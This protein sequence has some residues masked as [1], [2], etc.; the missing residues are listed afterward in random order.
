MLFRSRSKGLTLQQ[1]AYA[2]AN[3]IYETENKQPLPLDEAAFREVTSAEYM[4]FGRQGVG[5]PQPAEVRRM[6]G[7]ER[8]KAAAHRQWHAQAVAGIK[9]AAAALDESFAKIA[10]H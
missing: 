10:G 7:D 8:A 1:I 5:G 9:K 3:R 6:L 4:V 2:D